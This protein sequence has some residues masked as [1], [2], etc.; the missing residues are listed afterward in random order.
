MASSNTLK[1]SIIRSRS[2]DRP[3]L[4]SPLGFRATTTIGYVYIFRFQCNMPTRKLPQAPVILQYLYSTIPRDVGQWIHLDPIRRGSDGF[5][6]LAFLSSEEAHAI[7]DANS[8]LSAIAKYI[9][10]P[11]TTRRTNP[12]ADACLAH[13]EEWNTRYYTVVA[14]TSN[15]AYNHRLSQSQVQVQSGN[16]LAARQ[17]TT[18]TD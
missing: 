15:N 18:M 12:V 16:N 10:K 14:K 11:T 7:Q 3:T 2:A 9:G 6:S 4:G 8:Y 5:P 13:L 1:Q 17:S